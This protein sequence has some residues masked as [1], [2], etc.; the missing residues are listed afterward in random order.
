MTPGTLCLV[1]FCGALLFR[2]RQFL[3]E[4]GSRAWIGVFQ[5]TQMMTP[6]KTA[7]AEESRVP[8]NA[9]PNHVEQ[10]ASGEFFHRH[11]ELAAACKAEGA[12]IDSP[13]WMTTRSGKDGD[14]EEM[15]P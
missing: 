4:Q 15:K 8:E 1:L 5:P 10:S 11:S 13:P 2:G 7:I 12:D 6:V 3:S 14:I 9:C